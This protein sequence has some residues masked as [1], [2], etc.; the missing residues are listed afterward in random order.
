MPCL[1]LV[2]FQGMVAPASAAPVGKVQLT[3]LYV[4]GDIER[5]SVEVV[6]TFTRPSEMPSLGVNLAY[7]ITSTRTEDRF[8][9]QTRLDLRQPQT[10]SRLRVTMSTLNA[11]S[12]ESPFLYSLNVRLS[13]LE[14]NLLLER[15][16]PFGIRKIESRESRIWINNRGF[17]VRGCT[18]RET[19]GCREIDLET[20]R[21]RLRAMRSY[22]FNAE[23]HVGH[24][25]SETY[26]R[27][28]DEVGMFLQVEFS[29]L[30]PM[31]EKLAAMQ[32]PYKSAE[33]VAIQAAW[34]A[35][36]RRGRTHPCILIYG[37]GEGIQ[38]TEKGFVQCLDT[39][40]DRARQLDPVPLI[41]NR[42]GSQ[43]SADA[44]GKFDC[45][46]R[47][48]GGHEPSTELS[49]V[50]LA[51]YL[52]GDRKG[53]TNR[54]PVLAQDFPEVGSYPDLSD[55][56]RY[57][58]VPDWLLLAEN[59]A[60]IRGVLGEF[61]TFVRNARR[62]QLAALKTLVEEARKFQELDGYWLA[63]FLD[64]GEWVRGLADD[65]ADLKAGLDPKTIRAFNGETV[66]LATPLRSVLWNDEELKV[67]FT[68]SNM[69]N[70]KAEQ[71]KVVWS[72]RS[73]DKV[74]AKGES[75]EFPL[76]A[77]SMQASEF[78][79]FLSAFPPQPAQVTLELNLETTAD[80]RAENTMSLWVFPKD[81]YTDSTRNIVVWDPNRRLGALAK[82]YSFLYHDVTTVPNFRGENE[83]I[84]T[85]AWGPE[86]LAYLERGG[87]VFFINDKNWSH[88]P[89]LGRDGV[90]IASE[91]NPPPVFPDQDEPGARRLIQPMHH[92]LIPGNFGTVI[93]DHPSMQ[94]IPH[95]GFA[96]RQFLH[97]IYRAKTFDLDAFPVSITPIIRAIDGYRTLANKA[98]LFELRT[99]NGKL[100]LSSFN[101]A[102]DFASEPEVRYVFDRLMRY[103]IGR[104]FNP[105][106]S[107]QP[108]QLNSLVLTWREK[109]KN[110][111]RPPMD[112]NAER[113]SDK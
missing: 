53:L 73:G 99:G 71:A 4:I 14:G 15:N 42:C 102:Q 105:V 50:S 49:R 92:P 107:V 10:E 34:E 74:L 6:A 37:M 87:R 52:R 61:P 22:G 36:I 76:P 43:P 11:W 66:V 82:A 81:F 103:A 112:I 78:R 25:P 101:F 65:F 75:S 98:Y 5:M 13:D 1:V 57:E 95:E 84:I 109:L 46:Q 89:E 90:H 64:G 68:V 41:V 54:L 48:M 47:V 35:M 88:P 31:A 56:G 69:S 113:Y 77:W 19:D 94:G 111:P 96:D 32:E 70:Y 17:Y 24:I 2:G 100:L 30:A 44:H 83:L 26:L 45:I 38:N 7:R 18:A 23:R 80:F 86:L 16:Q 58:M 27:A 59:N 12:P 108:E 8:E 63:D 79:T 60:R 106:A 20:A 97:L 21:K 72:V 67:L 40:Y 3:E 91:T 104:D 62:T 93:Y 29:G 51:V 39:L 28:A 85:D 55:R 9:A 33:F 110:N